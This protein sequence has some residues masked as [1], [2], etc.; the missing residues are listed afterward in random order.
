M[1]NLRNKKKIKFQETY[2][3]IKINETR[4]IYLEQ[5]NNC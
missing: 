5:C 1:P 4:L 2:F 3:Y